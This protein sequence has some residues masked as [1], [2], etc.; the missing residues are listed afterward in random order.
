GAEIPDAPVERDLI[1]AI[2][3]SAGGVGQVHRPDL[4]AGGGSEC[5]VRADRD[6]SP[7]IDRIGEGIESTDV[8][9]AGSSRAGVQPQDQITE[10]EGGES[11]GERVSGARGVPADR[12][13]RRAG[14]ART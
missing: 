9:P 14:A 7:A 3:R 6:G 13:A 11:H 12:M 10:S 8:R 4:E 5:R 2:D 1:L